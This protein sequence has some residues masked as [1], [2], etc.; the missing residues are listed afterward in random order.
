MHSGCFM[1]FATT[2]KAAI[3]TL[4]YVFLHI[5]TLF[6]SMD[7][8]KIGL[9]S[10]GYEYLNFNRYFQITF[11]KDYSKSQSNL[12]VLIH[13]S[14]LPTNSLLQILKLVTTYQCP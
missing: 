4:F 6:L 1:I 12:A 14:L 11:H 10:Q 5:A 9:L 8:P 7:F 3:N 2:N 13:K